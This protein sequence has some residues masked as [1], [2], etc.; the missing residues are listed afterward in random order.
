MDIDRALVRKRIEECRRG[1]GVVKSWKVKGTN[2]FIQLMFPGLRIN[3]YLPTPDDVV[4]SPPHTH[5]LGFTSTVLYGV[6]TNTVLDV[7]EDPDGSYDR[8]TLLKP[9]PFTFKF[10][11]TGQRC[12]VIRETSKNYR[13]GDTY[14]M[15]PRQ[16]HSTVFAQETI[17]YMRRWQEE[18]V[19]TFHLVPHGR[20][21][22]LLP[23]RQVTKAE[24][25]GIWR[26]IDGQC[27]KAGI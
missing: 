8:C 9:T 17:T 25:P 21:M 19:Q 4:E 23:K 18:L 2:N 12:E 14:S 7:E 6:F 26:I 22:P 3:F 10:N 24:L 16:Y 1:A 15:D 27:E 5:D 20:K 13:A 11:N